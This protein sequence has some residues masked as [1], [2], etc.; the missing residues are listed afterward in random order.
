M[1]STKVTIDNNEYAIDHYPGQ[2]SR[3]HVN[4]VASCVHKSIISENKLEL[5]FQCPKCKSLFLALYRKPDP[6]INYYVYKQSYPK[7]PL[8]PKI[9]SELKDLSPSFYQ[10]YAQSM[11]ADHNG[12]DQLVGIGLRKSLEFLI[13][14]YS[15]SKHPQEE[16]AIKQKKLSS[17]IEEYIDYAKLKNIAKR[18]AWLGNDE[19]HY[20]RRWIDKDITDLKKLHEITQ[21]YVLMEIEADRYIA[22]MTI[23]KK[24]D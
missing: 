8:E 17:V 11:I 2:C 5:V 21:H 1:G 18:T 10:I 14:D 19:T 24:E 3:C 15:I 22:E 6:R 12:L 13:K 4:I 20:E 9:A 7:I 23:G 16:Q